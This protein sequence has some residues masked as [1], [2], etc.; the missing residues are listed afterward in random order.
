MRIPLG[1]SL[2]CL[3][4]AASLPAQVPV[5]QKVLPESGQIGSVLKIQG[6]FLDKT[7]VDEVYLSDHTFDMKV[8]V[9]D[10]TDDTIEFRVPPFAKPGR[11]QLVVKTTGKEPEILEQPV[12]ITV[13][14][15]KEE[16]K[17]TLAANS[18]APAAPAPNGTK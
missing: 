18:P 8:K 5:M 9:L 14:E 3:A 1:L 10:Q 16:P 4:G 11:L 12:Y 15:L 13:E 2:L 6:V 7:R 17:E